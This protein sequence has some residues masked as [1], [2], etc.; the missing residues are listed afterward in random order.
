MRRQADSFLGIH[1]EHRD[2]GTVMLTQ[3]KLLQKLFKEHPE[4]IGKRKAWGAARG[5]QLAAK[6]LR[7]GLPMP[8]TFSP[9]V[10]PLTF[11][12]MMQIAVILD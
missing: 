7:E 6:I 10:K 11:A 1:I 8:Q 5:D 12:S 2:D 4:K 9:T 3:P